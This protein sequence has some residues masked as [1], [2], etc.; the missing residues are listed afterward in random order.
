MHKPEKMFPV[1]VSL[2]NAELCIYL[3]QT[4]AFRRVNSHRM[5][6]PEPNT[7]LQNEDAPASWILLLLAALSPAL[8]WGCWAAPFL[9]YDDPM[10]F[11]HEGILG[12]TGWLDLWRIGANDYFYHPLTLISWR[13][14]R[15]ILAPLLEWIAGENAWAA[16]VRTT[17]LLL[18]LC[19]VFF[20]W[21]IFL[22]LKVPASAAIVATAAFAL[23]PINCEVI[24]WCVER[25]SVL[26]GSFG[27]LA[28][29]LY[30][31]ARGPRGHLI[32]CLAYTAS[33]LSKSS[34]IGLLPLIVVWE[35]LGRPGRESP[36]RSRIRL[37]LRLA[38][39][40]VLTAASVGVSIVF[41]RDNL[42]PHPGGSLF[43]ALLTDVVLLSRYVLNVLIPTGLSA[44]YGVAPVISP[45]EWRLWE[46]G[47]LLVAI[48]AGSVY[49]TRPEQRKLAILGWLWFFGTLGP[50]MNLIAISELMHDRY[51]Y[52]G[53]GGLW[54]AVILGVQGLCSR[55]TFLE[56]VAGLRRV[57]VAVTIVVAGTLA[58]L[59]AGRSH[60]YAD[61]RALF[62]DAIR[63]EP[64]SSYAH[65]LILE[66]LR[67]ESVL[68]RKN[69]DVER[70]GRLKAR[71]LTELEAGV[72]APDFGHNI[73]QSRYR[74]QLA[75][76]YLEMG[77]FD[78]AERQLEAALSPTKGFVI[79]PHDLATIE[80]QLGLL[81]LKRNRP[82][83]A[84][85]HF[86]RALAVRPDRTYWHYYRAVALLVMTD[87]LRKAQELKKSDNCLQ[88]ALDALE[89]VPE[90][91]REYKDASRLLSERRPQRSQE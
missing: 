8:V 25:K 18:H 41:Q 15:V 39:W 45:L 74:H 46:A 31:R 35:L 2:S 63:S 72:A 13:L 17:N 6:D 1:S 53:Q 80:H 37:L 81:S 22:Q 87:R 30:L 54:L 58:G 16:A 79:H 88:E 69:G 61:T 77:R 24:C 71:I 84:V 12:Q 40:V 66:D 65:L 14:D 55:I 9:R 62:E 86:N 23:S 83:K 52:L 38:P 36:N 4:G 60:V 42:V 7:S 89:K 91:S 32:A 34:T 44:M 57:T 20:L 48:V 19:S 33:L 21:R 28:V 82:D 3:G 26:A 49:F 11:E 76:I 51:V 73:M 67:A 90:G 85:A 5:H 43:T 64:D 50:M 10:M 75:A 78:D 29:W 70:H 27:L 68:A 59:S 56:R 47:I